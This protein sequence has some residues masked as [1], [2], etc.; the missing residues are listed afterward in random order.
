MKWEATGGV[1]SIKMGRGEVRRLEK[2]AKV[3]TIFRSCLGTRC[4]R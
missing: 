3:Q 1:S 2:W 4:T